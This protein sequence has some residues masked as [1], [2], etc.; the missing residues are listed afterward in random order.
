MA[1]VAGA[2][3]AELGLGDGLEFV[4]DERNKP[5][6]ELVRNG[7]YDAL[8]DCVNV[9]RFAIVFFASF[10]LPFCDKLFTVIDTFGLLLLVLLVLM[11]ISIT[12]LSPCVGFDGVGVLLR[13][14][15]LS[16][17]FIEFA[18]KLFASVALTMMVFDDIV[19]AT[20]LIGDT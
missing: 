20:G 19:T 3:C 4:L 14:T 11:S 1:G 12:L 16:L 6:A 9:D 5:S 15:W 13:N 17:G 8:A 18:V 10:S 2:L 7:L